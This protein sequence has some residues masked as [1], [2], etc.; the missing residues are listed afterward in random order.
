M[1]ST[2]DGDALVDISVLGGIHHDSQYSGV[3]RNAI[4]AR[5]TH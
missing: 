4:Q 2:V 1:K 5:Y 3:M